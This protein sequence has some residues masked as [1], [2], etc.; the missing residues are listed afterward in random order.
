MLQSEKDYI[1]SLLDNI[2]AFSS[3]IEFFLNSSKDNDDAMKILALFI[4]RKPYIEELTKLVDENGLTDYPESELKEK[5]KNIQK[6]DK[7]NLKKLDN[8]LKD[9]S[10]QLKELNKK[11]SLM[12]YKKSE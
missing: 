6:K 1:T 2:E 12:I 7:E 4:K 8:I 9:V 5:I 11:K 10:E 3:E